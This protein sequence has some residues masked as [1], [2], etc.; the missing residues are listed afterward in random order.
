MALGE[1]SALF[2]KKDIR[3]YRD[4]RDKQDKAFSILSLSSPSSL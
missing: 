4:E 1:R 3:F 2:T